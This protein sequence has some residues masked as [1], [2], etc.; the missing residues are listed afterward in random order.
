MRQKDDADS[1]NVFQTPEAIGSQHRNVFSGYC[2]TRSNKTHITETHIVHYRWHPWY[3]RTV[4]VFQEVD[5]NNSI[6]LRCA[7]ESVRTA[8]PLEVP[9]WMFD[10]TVC[11]RCLLQDSPAVPWD[12]LRQLVELLKAADRFSDVAVVQDGHLDRLNPGGAHAT[13]E[14]PA[15]RS[16]QSVSS[17]SDHSAVDAIAARDATENAQPA[18]TIA[19]PSSPPTPRRRP[20]KGGA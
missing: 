12:T 10:A 20:R 16:A 19:P 11:A 14:S 6:F 9:K 3:G 7:L 5:K 1:R 15:G 2:T 18:R 8:R 13:P 4:Y 17:G